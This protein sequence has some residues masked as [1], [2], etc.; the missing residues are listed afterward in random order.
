[1]ENAFTAAHL[2][3]ALFHFV[4]GLNGPEMNWK[5]AVTCLTHALFDWFLLTILV[6]L[7]RVV[8]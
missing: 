6:N 3:L 8:S 5:N 7:I 4:L 1:M 2:I